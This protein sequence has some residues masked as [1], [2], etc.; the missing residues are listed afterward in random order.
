MRFFHDHRECRFSPFFPHCNCGAT[1]AQERLEQLE[2]ERKAIE[3]LIESAEE[4]V[5][6]SSTHTPFRPKMVHA[7]DLED[8]LSG[9]AR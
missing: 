2:D 6:E 4:I 1:E 9:K 8:V 7:S 5:I 3:R